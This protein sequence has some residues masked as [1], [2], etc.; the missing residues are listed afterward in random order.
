LGSPAISAVVPT[1]NADWRLERTLES[2]RF[3]DEL[4]VVDMCSTNDTVARCRAFTQNIHVREGGGDINANVNFGISRTAHD[5]VMQVAQDH[6]VPGAL[7]DEV[8]TFARSQEGDILLA[9]QRNF[10]FGRE[11]LFGA[12]SERA[13][14]VAFKKGSWKNVEGSLHAGGTHAKDVR[15]VM[16]VNPILHNSDV[17]F[18]GMVA[19]F[20]RF[21]DLD[22]KLGYVRHGDSLKPWPAYR[23]TTRMFRIFFNLYVRRRG[24]RD[25]MH[26]YILAMMSAFYTFLEEAK[27]FESKVDWSGLPREV[28][29]PSKGEP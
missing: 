6:V 16:A 18:S 25:G 29:P 12:A 2:L 27:L 21:T 19:K 10:K 7:A 13:I 3:V 28:R 20:N 22:A 11:I 24:Y 23:V 5:T 17:S 14:P 1:F 26:G 9:E 8:R 4:I 15:R